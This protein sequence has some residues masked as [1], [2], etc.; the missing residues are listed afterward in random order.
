MM[1]VSREVLSTFRGEHHAAFLISD[2]GRGMKVYESH[3]A[4]MEISSIAE[5]IS[6]DKELDRV[7]LIRRIDPKKNTLSNL[8]PHIY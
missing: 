2:I 1:I 3:I 6:A 5:I 8:A 7:K 4:T